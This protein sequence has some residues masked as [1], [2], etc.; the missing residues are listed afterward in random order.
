MVL[1]LQ[2]LGCDEMMPSSN[3]PL[4]AIAVFI[5]QKSQPFAELVVPS[6]VSGACSTVMYK[7]FSCKQWISE[8][9]DE[10]ELRRY[11]P[12]MISTTADVVLQSGTLQTR[13]SYTGNP[14][15]EMRMD[16]TIVK[17]WITRP[18]IWSPGDH[19]RRLGSLQN[20]QWYWCSTVYSRWSTC[21]VQQPCSWSID[22]SIVFYCTLYTWVIA[23]ILW[24][25]EILHV[26]LRNSIGWF[27]NYECSLCVH[28]FPRLLGLSCFCVV[29]NSTWNTSN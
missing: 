5:T 22:Y 15:L 25:R 29:M 3:W 12:D 28:A 21:H 4:H 26:L 1:L 20:Q 17:V 10:D 8:P 24:K 19:P 14:I 2:A 11:Y 27:S 23:L 18:V 16:N 9:L 6:M 7:L 13:Y